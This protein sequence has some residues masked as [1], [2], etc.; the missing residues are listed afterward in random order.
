MAKQDFKG[1]NDKFNLPSSSFDE[2]K[3]LIQGYSK[4]ADG[5]TLDAIAKIT[6][7]STDT[8]TRNNGFLTDAGLITGGNT[9]GSTELGKRLARAFE[10]DHKEAIVTSLREMVQGTPFLS[11]IPSTVRIKNG[12]SEADLVNHILYASNSAKNTKRVTGANAIVEMLVA[13]DLLVD[14]NGTLRVQTG[15]STP[16]PTSTPTDT[17]EAPPV[18]EATNPGVSRPSTSQVVNALAGNPVSIAINIQ[19]HLPETENPAVYE[20]LFR[21]LKKH[22]LANDERSAG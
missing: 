16:E 6:G 5:A 3:K 19:L 21:S 1:S 11:D 15:K 8:V 18:A 17:K 20:N 4:R 10:H 2:L 13:A 7:T 22:L 14:D 12:M 9:K